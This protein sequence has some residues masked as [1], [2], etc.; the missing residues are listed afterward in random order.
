[1]TGPG[2]AP[3]LRVLPPEDAADSVQSWRR[4]LLAAVRR[5]PAVDEHHS[6]AGPAEPF[7]RAPVLPISPGQDQLAAV[8]PGS[9]GGAVHQA[10]IGVEPG[11]HPF[12]C[13]RHGEY[14]LVGEATADDL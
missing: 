2:A 10:R 14:G 4:V 1:M 8:A 6:C 3:L 7:H 11:Q 12:D 13:V 9:A 5:P